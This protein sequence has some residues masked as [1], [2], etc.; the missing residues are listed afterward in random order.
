[1]RQY[2]I[3]TLFYLFTFVASGQV[4]PVGFISSTS[5]TI[6]QEVYVDTYVT[7]GSQRWL[8]H[9]LDI[10][11]YND[12]TAIFF[13][14]NGTAWAEANASQI[15]AWCYTDFDPST[16][17]KLYNYY[18]IENTLNNGLVPYG[19]HLPSK[20]EFETLLSS[21]GGGGENQALKLM[22]PNFI[23]ASTGE[24]IGSLATND[25]DFNALRTK[26]VD[27]GGSTRGF[28][29]N[30]WTTTIESQLVNTFVT[31]NTSFLEFA[32]KSKGSGLAIRLINDELPFQLVVGANYQGGIIAYIFQEGDVGYVSGEIHGIIAA[33]FDD[34]GSLPWYPVN[35][36]NFPTPCIACYNTNAGIGFG[37]NNTVAIQ[38]YYN[39]TFD[40]VSETSIFSV[41]TSYNT[42]GYS[43]WFVP[44]VEE[45][46]KLYQNKESIG[47]F[48]A[49][50]YWSSND[51]VQTSSTRGYTV[52]FA[53]G[54]LGNRLKN[55][56]IPKLR[57]V[58]Y[59]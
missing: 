30:W 44:S 52:L 24:P 39:S 27:N 4:V 20:T 23:S 17:I 16:N 40:P 41:I 55:N 15:G 9:D 22:S 13:A 3:I 14:A 47:N 58:R 53:G 34:S 42:G 11:T 43:D 59:F 51:M 18:A 21:I 1:M 56:T 36:S 10:T 29:A 6:Q 46:N 38:G 31:N 8:D 54:T 7:I 28:Q 50:E 45:L 37:Y 12:G 5:E 49:S 33:E 19:W 2:I 35:P 26:Y 57:A 48:N 25:Y 32:T